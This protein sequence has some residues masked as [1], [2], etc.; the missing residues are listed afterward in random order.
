ME[1]HII[2]SLCKNEKNISWGEEN[3]KVLL[4]LLQQVN[5][6]GGNLF[7]LLPVE[8][9]PNINHIFV[10]YIHFIFIYI[11][12]QRN[13]HVNNQSESCY[14]ILVSIMNLHR[15]CYGNIFYWLYFKELP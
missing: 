12:L 7:F 1:T 3:F 10:I 14:T 15:L 8:S 9:F 13:C 11:L 5:D 4:A 2:C 6:K